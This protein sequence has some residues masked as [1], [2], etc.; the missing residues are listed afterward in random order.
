M[1]LVELDPD[2]PRAV[3]VVI[4]EAPPEGGQALLAI[5]QVLIATLARLGRS[6]HG[7]AHERFGVSN[8]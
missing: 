6:D 8:L 3:L 1:L 7:T 4:G 2:E 5:E